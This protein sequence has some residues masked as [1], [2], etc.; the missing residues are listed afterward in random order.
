MEGE[1]AG[2]AVAE[3]KKRLRELREKA[4]GQEQ[5]G[6]RTLKFRNYRPLDKK[7]YKKSAENDEANKHTADTTNAPEDPRKTQEPDRQARSQAKLSI[8]QQELLTQVS[9]RA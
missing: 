1:K 4:Q 2:D 3:R 6:S 5:E 8:V 9:A 7:L